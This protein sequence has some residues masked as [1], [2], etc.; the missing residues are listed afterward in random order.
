MK[1][2]FS[3]LIV[4]LMTNVGSSQCVDSGNYWDDS[5]VSCT[6]SSNP[7]ALRG[8]SKWL[9]YEFVE[10]QFIDSTHIW[11]ANR[12]GESGWGAKD[13]IIDYALGSGPW[14]ELGQYTFPQAPESETY[15]GFDGPEFNGVELDK[16][17]I[18]IVDN[19]DGGNCA[20]IAEIKMKIDDD[21]CYGI[22][23]V[24]GICDGLGELTWYEDADNDGLGNPDSPIT[25]CMQPTG[26]VDNNNDLCDDGSI[27]WFEIGPLLSDNGCTGCHDSN[28]A[29]GLNL[30][31]YNLTIAGG[32]FC[33]SDI[34]AGTTLVDIITN[35]GYSGCGTPIPPPAM[36]DRTGSQL[37][38]DEIAM[39]QYWVDGGTPEDC[40]DFCYSNLYIDTDFVSGDI[41]ELDAGNQIDADNIINVGA[42]IIYDAGIEINLDP[43]FEVKA[44]GQ[45]LTKHDGC[46]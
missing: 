35:S 38:A 34:T 45:F 18:T 9:L 16:I 14:L 43:G 24:C 42:N 28:A 12:T 22:V 13:V 17:L 1:Q 40:F 2:I 39:I 7:N 10:P 33:G 44:G 36:N 3:I 19:H 21:V 25:G 27:G 31:T 46:N 15:T 23:D 8:M 30:T 26:Y 29:G 4:F 5:W 32:D 41:E 37:D 11:N 20:S 6:D